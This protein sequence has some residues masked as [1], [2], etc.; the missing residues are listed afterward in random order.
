MAKKLISLLLVLVLC[1]GV[2]AAC[3]PKDQ[4]SQLETVPNVDPNT[5]EYVTP[6]LNGA[7][8]KVYLATILTHDINEAYAKGVVEKALNMD[9]EYVQLDAYG[10]A[11]PAMLA[12]GE[13]ADITYQGST[14][15]TTWDIYGEQGAF[16]NVLDYLDYM[17]NFK[18]F[19][20]EHW[21]DGLL[22]KYL[23]DDG[24]VMYAIPIASNAATDAWTYLYREDVFAANNLTWPKDQAAFEATLRKLKEL[25]PN[26]YPFAM[27]NLTGQLQGLQYWGQQWGGTAYGYSSYNSFFTVDAEGNNYYGLSCDAYK[28]M[29]E[30]MLRMTNEG[31]MHPSSFTMTRAQWKEA[32]TNNDCFVTFDKISQIS[33]LEKDA[34]TL[35]PDFSIAV[36]APF[37]LGTYATVTDVAYVTTANT[38]ASGAFTIGNGDNIANSIAYIDW[39]YSEEGIIATSWGVKGE[40]YEEDAD[41]NKKYIDSFLANYP[42]SVKNSGLGNTYN[43]GSIDGTAYLSTI[44][45]NVQEGMAVIEPY[46]GKG[47]RQYMLKFTEA[48]KFI[49]DTYGKNMTNFARSEL[50]KFCL[51]QRDI[52]EWEAYKEEL[53]GYGYDILLSIHNTALERAKAKDAG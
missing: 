40:S 4:G 1:V 36:G 24:T 29:A 6:N 42:T 37:N 15:S 48:E 49:W 27:T 8:V 13:I 28:E 34:Q 52:S 10:E 47:P 11:F 7:K 19:V 21:N 53:K 33:G 30:F 31:L 38:G 35:N 20:E 41:G 51:G 25:Y 17:P 46:R 16:I 18:K 3:G 2:L 44:D 32:F 22:D 14:W 23:S 12:D 43:C 45:E 50:A 26:S 5:G 9:L 39:L